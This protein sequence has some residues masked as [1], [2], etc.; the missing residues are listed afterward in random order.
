[1]GKL[2][3][4]VESSQTPMPVAVGWGCV[5]QLPPLGPSLAPPP[6]QLPVWGSYWPRDLQHQPCVGTGGGGFGPGQATVGLLPQG[7]AG[8]GRPQSEPLPAQT[9]AASEDSSCTGAHTCTHAHACT[10]TTMRSP[11]PGKSKHLQQRKRQARL[12]R[13]KMWP[14]Q[15][16]AACGPIPATTPVTMASPVWW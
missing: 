1:M 4:S 14:N 12:P 11:A 3:R 2:R 8:P 5:S 13:E 16:R 6:S 7:V 10:R 9:P 15:T